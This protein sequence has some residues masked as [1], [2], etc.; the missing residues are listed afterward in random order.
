ME[1]VEEVIQEVKG[2][3]MELE[4][5]C[6]NQIELVQLGVQHFVLVEKVVVTVQILD[7]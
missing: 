7:E 6:V 4:Y 5:M 2:E 3:V 1:V